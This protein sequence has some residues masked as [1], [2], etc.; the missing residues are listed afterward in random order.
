VAIEPQRTGGKS[1]LDRWINDA[2]YE[3]LKLHNDASNFDATALTEDEVLAI[4][5]ALEMEDEDG[6]RLAK[7]PPA[8]LILPDVAQRAHQADVHWPSKI[9][10]FHPAGHPLSLRG[11][12]LPAFRVASRSVHPSTE[13]FDPYITRERNRYVIDRARPGSALQWALICPLFGMALMIAAEHVNWIDG[14]LVRAV[15][16]HGT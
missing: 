8:E 2:R 3:R 10:V 9:E 1:R 13:G 12:Y 5:R 14:S 6:N 11:L 7:E 16:A 15:V 4:R